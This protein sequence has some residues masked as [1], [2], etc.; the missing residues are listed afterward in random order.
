[1]EEELIITPEEFAEYLNRINEEYDNDDS[2]DTCIHSDF[3]VNND[4]CN[5][6]LRKIEDD[7]AQ[8]IVE[9]SFTYDDI[10]KSKM[11][12]PAVVG[13]AK[14]NPLTDVVT[15]PN[16][17][18]TSVYNLSSCSTDGNALTIG[19]IDK[20]FAEEIAHNIRQIPA[21]KYKPHEKAQA[22]KLEKTSS[23]F[24]GI[25]ELCILAFAVTFIVGV[26]LAL[27]MMS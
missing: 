14:R 21:V 22:Q 6:K 25:I 9:G 24:V 1:M 26:V 27:Q 7:L 19:N 18:N 4:K 15:S 3:V 10:F 11:L 17:K 23:G 13:Y 12:I 2:L 5:H 8:T 16:P 20:K